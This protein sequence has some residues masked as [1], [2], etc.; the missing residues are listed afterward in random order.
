MV[1]SLSSLPQH[2]RS[3]LSLQ[4]VSPIGC[5]KTQWKSPKKLK[6]DKPLSTVGVEMLVVIDS[7]VD[8][9]S[10]LVAGVYPDARVLILNPNQDGIAQITDKAEAR[11]LHIVCHAAPGCLYLGSTRLS[12]E[13]L[14]QYRPLLQH[15]QVE[16]ILLYGCS[17]AASSSQGSAFLKRLHH[18]TN[19][20]IAASSTPVGDSLQ[21]GNWELDVEIGTVNTPLAFTPTLQAI[22]PSVFAIAR[23]SNPPAD[24]IADPGD[25][26]GNGESTEPTF[27]ADGNFIV[28]ESDAD[29][30]VLGDTNNTKDI[31]IYDLQTTETT[32]ISVDL[33]GVEGNQESSN[34]TVSGDGRIVVF[35]SLANNLIPED[36]NQQ[37]DIFLSNRDNLEITRISQDFAPT[38][39]G[40]T[41]AH[42]VIS[43][44]GNIVAFES[45]VSNDLDFTDIFLYDRLA[46]QLF[47][48]SVDAF[49]NEGNND[50]AFSAISN[51][52][53]A[54]VF[55]ST[56]N[57]L[58]EGDDNVFQDIFLYDRQT[59][60]ITRISG[61]VAENQANGDSFFAD[62]SGDG[63]F[64]VFESD[65]DN[66]VPGD[67]NGLR[68][69]FVFDR[70]TAITTRVSVDSSGIESNGNSFLPS[71]SNDGRF[72][73]FAS[74]ASN[75]VPNDTNG[76]Q[77][78]FVHDRLTAT[79]T[80]ITVDA[81]GIEANGNSL[82]SS[83]SDDGSLITFDSEAGNLVLSDTNDLRDV[84]IA[85]RDPAV[86]IN[87]G[88]NPS[89][90]G[91]VGTVEI[92]LN[93][94]APPG[95]L[96][97]NFS[98]G[99]NATNFGDY[100]LV[101]GENI[102][103][104][105]ANTFTI[106]E[107]QTTA[108]INVSPVDDTATDPNE[109]IQL[110]VEPGNGYSVTSLNRANLT[111]NDND[112]PLISLNR[113]LAWA[114]QLGGEGEE[115]GHGVAVD[116]AGNVYTAGQ[117]TGT[118]DFD[119]GPG[120]FNLSSSASQDIFVSKLDS[121]G[122]F[123]WAKQ[124]GREGFDV[125]WNLSV[126]QLGNVYTAGEFSGTVD[127]DPGIETFDLTS[128]GQGDIFVSKLDT[129]GNFVWAKQQ[130]GTDV[131]RA[132]S[133]TVDPAGNVYTT[134]EFEGSADFDP[135]PDAEFALNSL[136]G[137]DVFVS[138]L[139]TDGNFVW[140][141]QFGGNGGEK[142][143]T[144]AVDG[145]GNVYT[146]GSFR[147]ETD[148]DPSLGV[149]NLNST[150]TVNNNPSND[151]FVSK[152]NSEGNFVWARNLGGTQDDE[153]TGITVDESGNVYT[154]GFFRDTA[155]FD[156][157]EGT[158]NLSSGEGND[159]FI[160]KLNSEGNFVWARNF[161]GSEGETETF[162]DRGI[163]TVVDNS[164]NVYT[165]GQ[166][167]G[168]ADFDPGEGTANLSSNGGNDI[169]IS[170]L[171]PDGN[172]VW[173]RN[174]GGSGDDTG[175]SMTV[176]SSDNLYIT[177]DFNN[178]VDFDPGVGV[179][180]LNS[181][182][183]R[184]VFISKLT[185]PNVTLSSTDIPAANVTPGTINHVLYQLQ[186]DVKEANTE[187]T[188]LT[189]T[190]T[191]TYET[192]DF[193][194]D[195]FKLWS[196]TDNILDETDTLL[197]TQTIVP[198]N[199]LLTFTELSQPISR[200]DQVSLLITADIATEAVLGRTINIEPLN[201]SDI[202]FDSANRLG[203]ALLNGSG[204]QTFNITPTV[205]VFPGTTPQEEEST[206][207]T[208]IINLDTPAEADGQTINYNPFGSTAL[209]PDDY[210]IV[211]GEN[212]TD[213]TENSFTIVA[214]QTTAILN[215]IPLDDNVV[216]PEET[217]L[218]NL[219]AG[220]DYILNPENTTAN[221]TLIDDDIFGISVNPIEGIETSENGGSAVFE[222]VLNT[223]PLDDVIIGISSSNPTEGSISTEALI[224]TPENWDVPQTVTVTGV[225]DEIADGDVSYT[226]ITTPDLI[227]ND[228]N[229]NGLNPEDVTITNL[230]NDQPDIEILSPLELI[231]TED[232]ETATFEVVLTTQPTADVVVNLSSSNLDEG[233]ISTPTL[234]FTSENWNLPQAVTITGEDDNLVDGDILYTIITEPSQSE[235]P[236][237]NGINLE[238]LTVTNTDNDLPAVNLSVDVTTAEEANP[239]EITVTATTSLN[240]TGDQSVEV[241]ISGNG[242]TPEDYLLPI[243][244]IIIPDGNNTG[245]VTFSVV[246]DSLAEETEIAILELIN[247]S[248]GIIFGE[249]TQTNLEII[250]NDGFPTIEFSQ[251]NYQVNE[252]GTLVGV[253]ITLNRSGDLSNAATVEIQFSNETAIAG[254]D[255][256]NT[257]FPINFDPDEAQKTL[258]V[259]I[260][261]DVLFEGNE[262]FNLTLVNASEG[263]T[264]GTQAT[265]TVEILDNET[266]S[267]IVFNSTNL[268][269]SEGN[270]AEAYEIL[271]TSQP[272]SAVTIT[273]ET[274]DQINP[275]SA[276]TF[277]PENWNIP[278]EI[279]VTAIDDNLIEENQTNKIIHTVSSDDLN[280]NEL[281]LPEVTVEITDNDVAGVLIV[282][283]MGSTEVSEAGTLDLYDVV[284]TSQP[285]VD[286]TVT[287]TPDTQIDLGDGAENSIEL[288]FT[289]ETWNLPQQVTVQAI[290]D[291]EIE[292]KI[293]SSLLNH[294]VSSDDVNYN[295]NTPIFIDEVLTNDLIVNITDNDDISVPVEAAF[296]QVIQPVGRT[297]VIEGFSSDVYQILL[298]RQPT[299]DV[300]VTITSDIQLQTDKPTV[301]F[302]PE[303]W[304]IPQKIEVSVPQN[305]Q[306]DGLQIANITHTVTSE[307]T[308]YQNQAV[309]PIT[310]SIHD[311]DNLGEE[312]NGSQQLIQGITALDDVAT[313]SALDDVL[314][315]HSGNDRLSGQA[316][317]DILVGQEG[318]D[319]ITGEEG[320]D[321]LGGGEGDDH[322]YGHPGNDALFGDGGSDRLWGGDGNDELFGGSGSDRLSGDQG[323]DTL[324]GGTDPDA[325]VL[326]ANE[327]ET[328]IEDVD[329]IMDFTPG[330]D[331]IEL[332]GFL[333]FE[334]L[335]FSAPTE[336]ETHINLQPTGQT[337][338]VLLGVN[339]NTL[340]PE[341]FI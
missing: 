137:R 222:V 282:Q 275:I 78:I 247:P 162:N 231:T 295:P 23:I 206:L 219:T 100:N 212:I 81:N 76:L 240:V 53:N 214:G 267:F 274:E 200:D 227:T 322:L 18:L 279:L 296:V 213:L 136:G 60:D 117:F 101:A 339:I 34:A 293:H 168:T 221:L 262:T 205:S 42:P 150:L 20:N 4:F 59:Q 254:E 122:N 236:I 21:G 184:D 88:I 17:V 125:A 124:F 194:P 324:V 177:G 132:W 325:F 84:F 199:N 148:F 22:Y 116:P 233:T 159:I 5:L 93:Q 55:H 289:P 154:T 264:I 89:E 294:T 320:N 179:F 278:Q 220:E 246:D 208:F 252:D 160:S 329:I 82:H 114:R 319:G 39:E 286:V 204:E 12:W 30:L 52:G 92:S 65:A 301:T 158:A 336:S 121:E 202:L 169:F 217:I 87:P 45:R 323:T 13:N 67:T 134:G 129:D 110:T 269:V 161:G 255:F 120:V 338:A 73:S 250:D 170:K 271:L 281:V 307:D 128:R 174:L 40:I 62:I 243:P 298:S 201:F 143:L 297:D 192:T 331:V 8:H 203:I 15:W 70:S 178:S 257:A 311:N 111:I 163:S 28:F 90:V 32:R 228:P 135:N 104:L 80:R 126:D 99:G 10:T 46:D 198:S 259:P 107:G 185:T 38:G 144:V 115:I 103:N 29:N 270:Q 283:T 77:D 327:T 333:T 64:V 195:S 86:V 44:D 27:S 24:P 152:L 313:G 51:D 330:E 186:L 49:G 16:D 232:G 140:T 69:I 223:R 142:G 119:P 130:G 190:P 211:A 291:D 337:L 273:F 3:G 230:D 321:I 312:L 215:I 276:I 285:T 302:T 189:V 183:G 106:A 308:R 239:T 19:A 6:I 172:F 156:P 284:L 7:R 266:N 127:F 229:Y 340:T 2:K 33:N 218:L 54:V 272:T 280:F 35:D 245:S 242:I 112:D 50:S 309:D 1:L 238:D 334:Q 48:I 157:G 251:P 216:E 241:N 41:S 118:V 248:E 141:Q 304:N 181:L 79:T 277:N 108:T 31:F 147:G 341:N 288:L 256:D 72:V 133:V 244:Q 94:P 11:S 68:D 210:E 335:S 36:T 66:L 97:I 57:N 306:V 314:Y 155:D 145:G 249:S 226:I 171:T 109:I 207:G 237:Y 9:V 193:I 25:I 146:S 265:A 234:T 182:G 224:F 299:A 326:G 56:A 167:I 292:D 105:A 225:E 14:E 310:A 47:P 209:I 235:D 268:T 138:K 316:G 151:I 37:R 196:S 91:E 315:A 95:G 71:V 75:L 83:L 258:F 165:T 287:V 175:R 176:D 149:S 173:A 98:L 131:D 43:A 123:L 191:G 317:D 102:T 260:V 290:E 74:E 96:A 187:F 166:F 164:G 58:V 85:T 26:E 113:N 328:S 318:A 253:G 153:G 197:S 139:D 332:S 63:N 305:N 188:G 61:G 261:E 263:T 300:T 180:D 303:N